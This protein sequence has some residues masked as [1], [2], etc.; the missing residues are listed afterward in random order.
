MG[1]KQRKGGV[2]QGWGVVPWSPLD[3]CFFCSDDDSNWVEHILF[4]SSG[5]RSFH[6]DGDHHDRSRTSPS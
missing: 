2:N 6:V 3:I 4:E 1:S 5:I